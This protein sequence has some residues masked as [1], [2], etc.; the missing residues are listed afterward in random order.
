MI[1]V[2]ENDNNI[3]DNVSQTLGVKI[4]ANF[5][6]RKDPQ[7][8]RKTLE[9]DLKQSRSTRKILKQFDDIDRNEK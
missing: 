4:I 1:I 6:C 3:Y 2:D 5:L 9:D 8:V 7:A